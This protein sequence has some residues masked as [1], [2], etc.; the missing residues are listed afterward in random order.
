[1]NAPLQARSIALDLDTARANAF[2]SDYDTDL[3]YVWSNL[4]KKCSSYSLCIIL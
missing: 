4:S 3:E 1:V 2:P